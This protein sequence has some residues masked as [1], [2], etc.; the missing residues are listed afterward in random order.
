MATTTTKYTNS[1]TTRSTGD[2]GSVRMTIS[3]NVAQGNGGP[4]LP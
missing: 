3:S 2:G 1:D 4:S